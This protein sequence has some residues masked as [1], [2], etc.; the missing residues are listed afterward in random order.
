VGQGFGAIFR[1]G[2]EAAAEKAAAAD[3]AAAKSKEGHALN[4]KADFAGARD[5][6]HEAYRMCPPDGEF[7]KQS[8]ICLFSAG[9]MALKANDLTGAKTRYDELLALPSLDPTLRTKV[10]E[11][12]AA[13]EEAT[14]AAAAAEAELKRPLWNMSTWDMSGVF[15]HSLDD[16]AQAAETS[17]AA[18]RE[19]L[20]KA[21]K[22]A[23]AEKEAGAKSQLRSKLWESGRLDLSLF[24]HASGALPIIE[25]APAAAPSASE[26][27]PMPP[28]PFGSYPLAEV[29]RLGG[30]LVHSV[31]EH[32]QERTNWSLLPTPPPPW[33]W[34]WEPG[35]LAVNGNLTDVLDPLISFLEQN[36]FHIKQDK[37]SMHIDQDMLVVKEA[38]SPPLPPPRGA[39]V[40]ARNS[41]SGS[42]APAT[43]IQRA[44]TVPTL[45]LFSNG[46]EFASAAFTKWDRHL[47]TA[48]KS[49][50]N[51]SLG[52]E[53]EPLRTGFGF[54]TEWNVEA[55]TALQIFLKKNGAADLE[56]TQ[57]MGLDG[58]ALFGVCDND[59][60]IMALQAFLNRQMVPFE[61]STSARDR[62]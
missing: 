62:F 27:Q 20:V 57:R 45:G 2:G 59:P 44:V 21:E 30:A 19:A 28:P 17:A 32:I 1:V 49:F 6:F 15:G 58:N 41:A 40:Q 53:R 26:P 61:G 5:A 31:L 36:G 43:P 3:A 4:E 24:A 35:E 18:E 42:S 56:V 52:D 22:A 34:R 11:K 29:E 55:V 14:A 46:I 8:A 37:L 54:G 9:N 7:A 33:A 50:L 10:L 48:L 51:R 60:T 39:K 16:K 38:S 47:K 23:A 25:V 12:A 13:V